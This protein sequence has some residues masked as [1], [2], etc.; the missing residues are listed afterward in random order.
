[1][2][3]IKRAADWHQIMSV[4]EEHFARMSPPLEIGQW[5]EVSF[6]LRLPDENHTDIGDIKVATDESS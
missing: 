2:T 6:Y 4:L 3:S 1:M 5:Y